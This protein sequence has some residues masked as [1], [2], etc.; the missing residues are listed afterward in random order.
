M[1]AEVPAGF[2]ICDSCRAG[3][4]LLLGDN[5]DHQW[6]RLECGHVLCDPCR[7]DYETAY[8]KVWCRQCK[9]ASDCSTHAYKTAA[10]AYV[11]ITLYFLIILISEKYE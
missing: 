5:T 7:K 8:G 9:R 3:I 10:E 4:P 2:T 6:N 11:K 1:S